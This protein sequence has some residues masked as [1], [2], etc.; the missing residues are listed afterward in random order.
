MDFEFGTDNEEIS[1]DEKR[2]LIKRVSASPHLNRSPRLTR[3]LEYLTECSL[4]G[5]GAGIHEREIGT[6]V[7]DRQENYDTSQDNIVR[8]QVGHLRRK[9]E[10]YF[11]TD[12]LGESLVL[13]IPKGGYVPVFYSKVPA[14]ADSAEQ[15]MILDVP[16]PSGRLITIDRRLAVAATCVLIALLGACLWLLTANLKAG[17]GSRNKLDQSPALNSLWSRLLVKDQP[18]D[19]VLADSMLSL[20]QDRLARQL[21]LQEYLKRDYGTAQLNSLPDQ[22]RNDLNN[23]I[24]RRYTSMADVNL[25]T[26][27]VQLCG[28]DEPPPTIN[29]ARDYQVR[30]L[31]TNNVIIFGSKRSNPWVEIFEEQTNFRFVYGEQSRNSYIQNRS[32]QP[33]EQAVYA[34]PGPGE[35][36]GYALVTFLPNLGRT[37]NVLIVQGEDMVSTEAAGEFVTSE[38][39]F[40]KFSAR[41]T[42]PASQPAGTLAWFEALLATKKVESAARSVEV[43]AFRT[44]SF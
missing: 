26:R 33:G 44:L 36:R 32:P 2:A 14:A 15:L 5:S 25:L 17:R 9:I 34:R 43:I 21:T 30:N 10:K 7:F 40:S 6:S 23:I 41:L 22:E 4:D 18:T 1:P 3:L 37:G 20:Y 16:R 35:G 28:L 29:F 24:S 13:E 19:V 11:A 8:V 39:S 42:P 27:I 12:G 38:L 31:K